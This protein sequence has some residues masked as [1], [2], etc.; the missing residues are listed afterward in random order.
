[1]P[2]TPRGIWTPTD[3]DDW[4]L[5]TDL[6]AFAVSVDTAIGAALSGL[7]LPTRYIGTDAERSALTAPN[8]R[9]G[10]EFQTTDTNLI[11]YRVSGAWTQV[12]PGQSFR[13]AAG[14]GTTPAGGSVAVTFPAGRF[15]VAPKVT[16]TSTSGRFTTITGVP[17]TTGMTVL[18]TTAAG[19]GA[20]GNFDWIAV[21]MT[22]ASAAG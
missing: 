5:I 18:Q 20:A 6:A 8:L 17:T 15:T 14:Q 12:L 9:N 1:M 13:M 4:D 7:P 21:Q 10:I 19:A 16:V 2:T 22:S 3:G 11:W